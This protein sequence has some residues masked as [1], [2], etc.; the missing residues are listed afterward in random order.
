VNTHELH[1]SPAHDLA[2]SS[3]A[4]GTPTNISASLF[5]CSNKLELAVFQS[6]SGASHSI[7]AIPEASGS[8]PNKN[9]PDAQQRSAEYSTAEGSVSG[10]TMH[11]L[12]GPKPCE[13]ILSAAAEA[14]FAVF[15]TQHACTTDA[16]L[17]HP[18]DKYR[19]VPAAS[20]A[21]DKSSMMTQNNFPGSGGHVAA[22]VALVATDNAAHASLVF[23]CV[24]MSAHSGNSDVS[25]RAHSAVSACDAMHAA[26]ECADSGEPTLG[27]GVGAPC[28]RGARLPHSA[29]AST[30]GDEE[31][32]RFILCVVGVL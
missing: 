10:T 11:V 3:T 4:A 2:S 19:S 30:D 25:K 16:T 20:V 21:L 24:S 14:S 6:P 27:R 23:W 13:T 18:D 5:V 17:T 28:C 32:R 1:A 12:W 15:R 8:K 22:A 31:V 9:I 29:A 26:H 7:A